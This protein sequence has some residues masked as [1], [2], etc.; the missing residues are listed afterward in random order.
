[1]ATLPVSREQYPSAAREPSVFA[2]LREFLLDALDEVTHG[3]RAYHIWMATLTFVMCC[4]AFAYS[5]QIS[6]GLSVTGMHDHV[7]WGLYISNFTFLV[8]IAA[9]A[10]VLV[11]PTYVLHDVAFKKAV[12]IGEAM[13][14][15]AVLM[16]IGFVVVDVGGPARLWHVTPFIGVFNWPQSLLAWD[17][18]V[19]NVYLVL[20]LIIPF[21]ILFSHYRNREPDER[22]YVPAMLMSILWAVSLHLV[23]AFLFAG[24]A[25]RPHWNNALMGPRFLATA[26]TAGPALMILVL[27]ALSRATEYKIR[28]ETIRK[29]ALVAAVAAQVTVVMTISELF[30]EFYFPTHHS[31]SSQYLYFGLDGHG[32]LRGWIWTALAMIFIATAILSVHKLRQHTWT[33]NGACVMLFFGILIEKG[34]GTVVPGFIPEQWGK[35]HE[36]LPTGTELMVSAGIWAAGAFVFTVLAKVGVAIELGER[37][38][39]PLG[40]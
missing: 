18:V 36:Y 23:T 37:R 32:A 30:K 5:S 27:Q 3:N 31:I 24:L 15:S 12:L 33:L 17:I 35:I 25:A 6:Q 7:S 22:I 10:V 34:L 13:A 26:F 19:L 1:M 9:A 2:A 20:N 4:G 16:A 29:V 21:Y 11:L 14:V 8:G 39:T 38:V 40:Q 28:E